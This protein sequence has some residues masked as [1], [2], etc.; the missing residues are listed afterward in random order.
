[1]GAE[2]P[3]VP[4][5]E[6]LEEEKIFEL[7]SGATNLRLEASGVLAKDWFFY[8]IFDNIPHIG[9]IGGGL[10][11]AAKENHLI[12]QDRSH[13]AGYEDIAYDRFSKRFY[14]LIEALPHSRCFMAQVD[15]YDERFRYISSAWLDF[16][17]DRPNK[18]LEGL[19]CI[20]RA[21][22]TYLLGL[23]EGNRCKGGAAGRRPGGGRIQ[24]FS[25]EHHH[26]HHVDTMRLPVS[27][28]FED[29][30][31]LSVDDD[32]IAVVSQASSAL[33]VGKF[34]PSS[35][36]IIDEG[37][38]YRF[39][40]DDRGKS[41]YCNV[42]GISWLAPDRVVVVSDRAK[43]AAQGKRCR[44]KDES[45]HIFTIPDLTRMVESHGEET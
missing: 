41:V 37:S 35:W 27:L 14:L 26:W 11:R 40:H 23:C 44:D 1:M 8:L 21:E 6:L 7:L 30:S 25:K 22:Q 39:P 15:E 42:E 17:L 43:A 36:E 29:Y 13:S 5:L 18:G 32:R 12:W 20:H 9:R 2:Q 33:W 19:D 10:S 16:P 31:S 28:W 3:T 34:S 38:I 24:I 4:Q 45:I